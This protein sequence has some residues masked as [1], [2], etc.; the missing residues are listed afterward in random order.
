MQD[1]QLGEL[2]HEGNLTYDRARRKA[3]Y[4]R[5]ERRFGEVLPSHTIVWRATI[6]AW[7][8][9]LHGVRPAPALSDFW[10]VGTWTI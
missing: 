9:D 4:A 1:A 5:L 7:N 6:N 10:N 3:V 2:E 8:D